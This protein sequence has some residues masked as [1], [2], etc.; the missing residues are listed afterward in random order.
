V[1][2]PD[3]TMHQPRQILVYA[4]L[5]A[6]AFAFP[7]EL[8]A[9]SER[10]ARDYFEAG[11]QAYENEDYAAALEA[12]RAAIDAG[13]A[14]PA[15]HYN[16]GVVAYRLELLDEAEAAFMQVARTPQMTALAWYNLGLVQLRRDDPEGAARWFE[17]VLASSHDRTLR[18]LAAAQLRGLPADPSLASWVYFDAGIGYDDNV[19]L[20]ADGELLGVSGNESPFLETQLAAAA[21]A[22]NRL[23]FDGAIF[24]VHFSELD[25]L[26]QAAVMAGTTWLHSCREWA[27]EAGLQ[28]GR[29]W[30]DGRSFEDRATLA[31]QGTRALHDDWRLRLRYRFEKLRGHAP[32]EL[33]DGDRHQFAVRLSQRAGPRRVRVEYAFEINDREGESVSPERHQLQGE[34]IYTLREGYSLVLGAGYRRSDIDLEDQPGWHEDR[35]LLSLG[36]NKNLP[37]DWE[38]SARYDYTRNRS[39]LDAADYT[40]NR[41]LLGFNHLF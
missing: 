9:Q 7:G 11:K 26:D 31:F 20:T 40:R 39:D 19:A 16:R 4:L 41:V 36:L 15:V 35:L 12:F 5:L 22:S 32:F 13:L 14:G 1:W 29:S 6:I 23:R 2:I 25:E 30:L 34:A 8:L 33:L 10:A 27:C 38:L 28:L 21:Y 17:K 3:E 24:A 18:D 37:G